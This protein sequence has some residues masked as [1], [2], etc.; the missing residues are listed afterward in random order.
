NGELEQ[1][2]NIYDG[3]ILIVDSNFVVVKDTYAISE[4]KTMISEEII[5]CF[6]GE[7]VTNYD[8]VNQYIEMTIPIVGAD[9]KEIIGAMLTS[10][11]TDSIV[12]SITLLKRKALILE[13]T[14]GIIISAIAMAVSSFLVQPFARVTKAISSVKEGF[15][16]EIIS[17]PDY[18]ET[19]SIMDAFNQLL[20]RMKILDDSR[21]EF[22]AN[23]SHE[24]KTPLASMKVL[25]D[26]LIIQ[27]NAP[28]ELYREF[29]EDI[30]QEIDR[31]NTIIT[32]L[33]SLV[34]MDK[35][36]GTLNIEYVDINELM[37]LILRRLRPI[38]AKSNIE[39]VFES[40]RPVEA[41]VDEVK[42]TLAFSNLI[43]NAIK[44]NRKNGWV[45]VS[46]NADHQFFTLEVSDSGIGIPE[47]ACEHIFERF[48]RVDKSHSREIGGTGL[49]LAITR[50]AILMHRG[51]I[52]VSSK[53]GEGTTFNV[54]VPLFYI[55]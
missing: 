11:S 54:K 46:L 48:Y 26:S 15:W 25:A 33:L 37:E 1:L 53:E 23:V 32:D 34:K 13:I 12:D 6:K 2:S 44:Y 8:D 39:V 28:I 27:D 38:A 14:M 10:V 16:Q 45:K 24:L 55:A 22:V 35:I 47:D 41:E 18:A 17:I 20:A 42:L 5:K 4:A 29:M 21:E 36:A 51:A 43:E 3:R 52:K 49:G 7:N 30:A 50:N 19:E 40:L 31:E 9:S